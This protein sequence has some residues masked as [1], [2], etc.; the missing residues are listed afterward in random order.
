MAEQSV[1]SPTVND[2]LKEFSRPRLPSLE[3][4][5][6]K[7]RIYGVDQTLRDLVGNKKLRKILKERK[8][9]LRDYYLNLARDEEG[10][11]TLSILDDGALQ[12]FH[13]SLGDKGEVMTNFY[14]LVNVRKPIK[15]EKGEP[16]VGKGCH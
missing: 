13:F 2:V 8:S 16:Q 10:R 15:R 4:R 12:S 9:D 14:E 11:R 3:E 5:A 6:E 1:G 7:G